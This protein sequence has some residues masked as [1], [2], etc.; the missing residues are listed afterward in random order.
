[1]DLVAGM[2]GWTEEEDEE[3]LMSTMDRVVDVG[4]AVVLLLARCC[5]I[6]KVNQFLKFKQLMLIGDDATMAL[7]S[8]TNV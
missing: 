1:M 2:G 6:M 4:G 7:S 5:K 3:E 8:S